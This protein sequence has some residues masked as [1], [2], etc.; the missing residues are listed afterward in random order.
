MSITAYETLN[1]IFLMSL[2][3]LKEAWHRR[4]L[5]YFNIPRKYLAVEAGRGLGLGS[6]CRERWDEEPAP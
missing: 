3:D 6:T 5:S 2:Q 1:V 4:Q